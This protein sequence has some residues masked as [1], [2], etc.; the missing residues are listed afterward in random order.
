M[1]IRS[2]RPHLENDELN[3]KEL[4]TIFAFE[5]INNSIPIGMITTIKYPYHTRHVTTEE[6]LSVDWRGESVTNDFHY[7]LI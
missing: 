3:R 1:E 4:I 5:Q 2:T 7:H 6:Q